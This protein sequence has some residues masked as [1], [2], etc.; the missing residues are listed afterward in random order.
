MGLGCSPAVEHI[1][2]RVRPWFPS[3]AH[4]KMQIP[5]K[6]NNYVKSKCSQL[7][8]QKLTSHCRDWLQASWQGPHL[9]SPI[10]WGS[11]GWVTA[12]VFHVFLTEITLPDTERE[13]DWWTLKQVR[14]S[15]RLSLSG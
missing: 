14:K 11:R 6:Q 1:L 5:P 10:S 3:L 8:G 2:T 9:S 15:R 7:L 13:P 4:K 12:V